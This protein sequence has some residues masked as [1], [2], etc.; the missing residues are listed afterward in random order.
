MG[1]VVLIG[2]KMVVHPKRKTLDSVENDTSFL[3][4]PAFSPQI[5]QSSG[6][7]PQI[8]PHTQAEIL[9]ALGCS[10]EFNLLVQLL[11]H[12]IKLVNVCIYDPDKIQLKLK[13]YT[14]PSE[15]KGK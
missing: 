12:V 9:I 7:N 3:S 1:V 13:S 8:S 6:A 4:S 10:L 14:S 11:Q 2:S 15:L 5:Y